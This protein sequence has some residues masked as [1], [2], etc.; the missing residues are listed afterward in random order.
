MEALL[1]MSMLA[2]RPR[3]PPICRLHFSEAALTCAADQRVGRLVQSATAVAAAVPPYTEL[4]R[5]SSEAVRKRAL[6][7]LSAAGWHRR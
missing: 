5:A 6:E 7:A 1:L 4:A 3:T 2:E